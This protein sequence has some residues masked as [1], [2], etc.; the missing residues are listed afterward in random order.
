MRGTLRDFSLSGLG[1][2]RFALLL[3]LW[4]STPL[5]AEDQDKTVAVLITSKESYQSAAAAA[6][7]QLK[8]SGYECELTTI[9]GD[10]TAALHDA[11][12]RIRNN[13]PRIIIAG[14]AGVTEEILARVPDV[15]VVFMMTP[16]ALD[17]HFL[18][19][20]SPG[21]KRVAGVSSD[22]APD[23]L[24]RWIHKTA[25]NSRKIAVLCSD[26]SK[27]TVMELIDAAR[28]LGVT[29][30]PVTA[31]RDQFPAAIDALNAEAYD[32]VLMVPDAQV[33][34]APNVE[35]LLLWG[36]REKHP[37]W[38]FSDKLVKSG[39]L[40]AAY[41]EPADVGKKAAAL[42]ERILKG[43]EP[44]DVGVQHAD[45]TKQAVNV[46]TAQMIGITL[47]KE[48][49]APPVIRYGEGD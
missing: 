17:C 11:L 26:N 23:A 6:V 38:A 24:I 9:F 40:A 19:P 33:Y 10:N 29:I 18:L 32:G 27:K 13:R 4:I 30:V 12:E 22:P 14:G 25:P 2:W 49:L 31:Q 21:L 41:C 8:Q 36:L 3:V 37:V 35:R 43:E 20:S 34:N 28:P 16:N 5:N 48:V 44:K 46:R 42:A 1:P 7:E 39:A 45:S 47:A 15:P